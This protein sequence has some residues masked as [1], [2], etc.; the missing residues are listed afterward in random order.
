MF[1]GSWFD[2]EPHGVPHCQPGRWPDRKFKSRAAVIVK[3]RTVQ[4]GSS[5]LLEFKTKNEVCNVYE[6]ALAVGK[7]KSPYPY[8]SGHLLAE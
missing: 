6:N 8:R 4:N 3:E 5:K 7:G 2:H 1:S